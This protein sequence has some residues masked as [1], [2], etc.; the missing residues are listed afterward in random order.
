MDLIGTKGRI[1]LRRSVATVMFIHRGAFMTPVEGH[2]WE[3]VSL[4]EEDRITGQHLQGRDINSVLQSRLIHSLLEPDSPD[5]DPISSGREGRASLE[6]IHGSWESHRQS[7][8]VPFPL[9]DRT[10]PLQRWREA[11]S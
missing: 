4:P 2:Q 8:R 10:H 5:A 11:S 1:A 3:P 9:K 6:M 7:G